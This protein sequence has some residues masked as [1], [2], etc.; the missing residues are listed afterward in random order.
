MK[1]VLVVDVFPKVSTTFIAA[2][3]V[4]LVDRG[5]DAHV[6]CWSS[7]ADMWPKLAQLADRPELRARVHQVPGLHRPWTLAGPAAHVGR[8]R[9]RG[10]ALARTLRAPSSGPFE[11]WLNILDPDLVHFEFGARAA[12][13]LRPG[14]AFAWPAVVSFR[15]YDLNCGGL[16][17]PDFYKGVW[18][19]ARAV[20]CLGEDLWR[21]AL[22]RGC[23]PDMPH[24]L[25]PPAVDIAYF[26]P[27]PRPPEAVGTPARPLRVLSVG[28]LHWK[29]GFEWAL[30]A[31]RRLVQSG[32]SVEYRVVGEGAEREPVE[33]CVRDLGLQTSVV[34][35]GSRRRH[36][37]R[38]ELQQADVFLHAA[39]SEGFCNAVMEAQ[40][41]EVPVVCSDADGLPE[42]VVDGV[43]GFVVER[44]R[45]GPMAD[46][47]AALA[48]DAELRAR[49]GSAGR[50]R[51]AEEFRPSD[52][53]DAFLALYRAVHEG[54]GIRPSATAPSPAGG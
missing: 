30:E 28:R 53:I 9:G 22:R 29:K 39:V 33:A 8:H 46:A 25:I 7:E 38:E 16:D 6:V 49:M 34:M 12:R 48:A 4:G 20:H 52:Q 15:G 45:P 41:M 5:I 37:V 32:V 26:E 19:H 35:L 36:E 42:N 11:A 1:V 24:V 21:R 50:R 51:V 23:P 31:V 3:F 27:R 13:C 14:S 47:L 10:R 43:T 44:R 2:K 18:E 54:G 17:V 40:A